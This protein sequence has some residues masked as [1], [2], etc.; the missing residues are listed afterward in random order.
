[1]TLIMLIDLHPG[2]GGCYLQEV[3]KQVEYFI[4]TIMYSCVP[5]TPSPVT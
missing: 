2:I 3:Y 4:A 1:M 5:T